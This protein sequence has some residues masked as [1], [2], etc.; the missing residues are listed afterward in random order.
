M[1]SFVW[2]LM[3]CLGT[4]PAQLQGMLLP[5]FG[6]SQ[7]DIPSSP[8]EMS[9]LSTPTPPAAPGAVSDAFGPHSLLCRGSAL[10]LCS[11]SHMCNSLLLPKR[12]NLYWILFHFCLLI[13]QSI[14]Q[15]LI[16]ILDFSPVHEDAWRQHLQPLQAT[17]YF[18]IQTM[19]ENIK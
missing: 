19:N 4:Q 16:L 13:F 1:S 2:I 3:P 5:G 6:G 15:F 10:P 12:S 7:R 17:F 14:L 11:R 18:I 9:P 8:G